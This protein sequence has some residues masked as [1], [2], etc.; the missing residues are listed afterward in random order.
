MQCTHVWCGGGARS[1]L[2]K[3]RS[4]DIARLTTAV[5]CDLST[6]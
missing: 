4:A 2:V 1:K 6:G 3:L 5:I